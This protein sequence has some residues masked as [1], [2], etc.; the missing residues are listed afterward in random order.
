MELVPGG[1]QARVNY[2]RGVY[3]GIHVVA[4]GRS[5]P[6]LLHSGV[7]VYER[8]LSLRVPQGNNVPGSVS[9][10]CLAPHGPLCIRFPGALRAAG[11][12][13]LSGFALIVRL[14]NLR[15]HMSVFSGK[16][17]GGQGGWWSSAG[18]VGGGQGGWWRSASS[19]DCVLVV[20]QKKQ[21]IGHSRRVCCT[22]VLFL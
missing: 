7:G 10:V 17:G 2:F 9:V 21:K 22:V 5:R 11:I 19:S 6:D 3:T 8:A 1:L 12:G 20:H 13:R 16:V 14:R 18:K 15:R 4:R